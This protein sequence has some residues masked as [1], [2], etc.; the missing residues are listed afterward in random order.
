MQLIYYREEN[1]TW[2][3]RLASLLQ[4]QESR[5]KQEAQRALRRA[6]AAFKL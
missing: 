3:D 6:V 1:L 5:E 2:M 4:M